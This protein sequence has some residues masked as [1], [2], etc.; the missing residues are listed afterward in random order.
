MCVVD[1]SGQLPGLLMTVW[2]INNQLSSLHTVNG[3][4]A[5]WV[6]QVTNQTVLSTSTVS[7]SSNDQP[8]A[9]AACNQITEVFYFDVASNNVKS[10]KP[11]AGFLYTG[12]STAA[13]RVCTP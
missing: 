4:P 11:N 13:A 2:D 12:Y 7:F 6:Q 5:T 9:M 1:V 8:T 10:F 3:D